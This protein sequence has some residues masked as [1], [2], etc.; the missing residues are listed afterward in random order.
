[1][2]DYL[3]PIIS[4]NP[5]I[6]NKFIAGLAAL[7]LF[8]S[9]AT[10]TV[11]T[12]NIPE[13]DVYIGGKHK[14]T[15]PYRHKD[16][17]PM[18]WQRKVE[19]KKEGYETEK[20][21]IGKFDRVNGMAL[22][23]GFVVVVPWLWSGTYKHYYQYDLIAKGETSPTK[24][25]H[26]E[27]GDDFITTKGYKSVYVGE[28]NSQH[29]IF[30]QNKLHV[31]NADMDLQETI[32]LETKTKS[33]PIDGF[34]QN[35]QKNV[36]LLDKYSGKTSILTINENNKTKENSLEN[37]L[38]RSII[39]EKDYAQGY[40]RN[41]KT[42]NF[43]CYS[44]TTLS[45]YNSSANKEGSYTSQHGFIIEAYIL[46]DD[47]VIILEVDKNGEF[48]LI[49]F[50]DNDGSSYA[51]GNE[52]KQ[53]WTFPRLS[54]NEATGNVFVSVLLK[55]KVKKKESI[56]GGYVAKMNL[57][58]LKSVSIKDID[59]NMSKPTAYLINRGVISDEN[60]D[61]LCIESQWVVTTTTTSSSGSSTSDKTVTG[62][63]A[64][65]NFSKEKNTIKWIS[66]YVSSSSHFPKLSGQFI[67]KDGKV[68]CIYNSMVGART[69]LVQ[70]VYDTDL[71]YLTANY[72]DCYK[73]DRAM[74]HPSRSY[75]TTDGRTV[76]L[77]H[78][79]TK[80]GMAVGTF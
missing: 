52:S 43:I 19:I 79:K 11:I 21:W 4:L 34:I 61:I 62:S 14:G 3:V 30:N 24:S 28:E 27:F 26:L 44:E 60:N 1:M 7:M 18:G 29:Y 63:A 13:S 46:S 5:L 77:L 45:V 64:L 80:L 74:F 57:S 2:N 36:V 75:E 31:L 59:L 65:V 55:D 41:R 37:I 20:D 23:T 70:S 42:N 73:E 67:L 6:M 54:V 25:N 68:Y 40:N 9:C 38:T 66:K 33:E 17:L 56:N 16:L 47:R 15:T 50:K 53:N 49:E 78:Y 76:F 22:F 48:Y 10:T 39:I 12:S 58:D 51:V 69:F 35:G 8:H 71:N 32:F 72:R